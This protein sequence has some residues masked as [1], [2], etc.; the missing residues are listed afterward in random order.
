LSLQLASLYSK[1]TSWCIQFGKIFIL[2][3]FILAASFSIISISRLRLIPYSKIP[4]ARWVILWPYLA[5][6]YIASY[7]V[8]L[9]VNFNAQCPSPCKTDTKYIVEVK[10]SCFCLI[11]Y[12][13]QLVKKGIFLDS[14][15]SFFSQDFK[16]FSTNQSKYHRWTPSWTLYHM[17]LFRLKTY[18]KTMKF[19]FWKVPL[20]IFDFLS[21]LNDY[22]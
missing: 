5:K 15:Y 14:L 19:D 16:S 13:K 22:Y 21:N 9:E 6:E 7:Q 20:K 8:Y 17:G 3:I 11:F 10:I 1:P 2:I 12:L 4:S 18:E